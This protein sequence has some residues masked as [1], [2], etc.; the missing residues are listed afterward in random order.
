[1]RSKK[2]LRVLGKIIQADFKSVASYSVS[3]IKKMAQEIINRFFPEVNMPDIKIIKHTHPTYLGNTR[4]QQKSGQEPKITIEF[5]QSILDD[6]RTIH[7][8]LAHELI[9]VWQYSMPDIR[10]KMLGSD[11]K[12]EGHGKSFKLMADKMNSH[13][14]ENYVTERSDATDVI[15]QEKEFYILIQPHKDNFFGVTKFSRPSE[16]QKIEIQRRIQENQAHVFK[17]K[18]KLFSKAA[19]VKKYGGYSVYENKEL[20]DRLAEMYKMPN[21]DAKFQ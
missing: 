3:D 11:G 16:K 1:M 14:G 12:Y 2:L 6:E 10:D 5:Q 21:I 17:T 9:H 8:T 19:D 7:R 15:T 13:Y 4:F 20:Q 18:E